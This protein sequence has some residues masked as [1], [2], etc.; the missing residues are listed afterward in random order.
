MA[1]HNPEFAEVLPDQCPP[2]DALAKFNFNV[3]RLVPG[4]Q[5]TYA[6]FASHAAKGMAIRGDCDPCRWASC[7]LFL[8]PDRDLKGPTPVMKL[9]RL[10]NLCYL[11]FLTVDGSS[12]QCLPGA[13]GHLDF[14]MYASF[15]PVEAVTKVE[16]LGGNG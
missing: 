8:A 12:G 10:R 11:A 15:A 3:V 4:S 7:S 16:R 9:P 1:I 5:A 6:D 13:R 14:W 2:T